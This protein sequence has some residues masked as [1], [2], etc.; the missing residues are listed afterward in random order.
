MT[1]YF[2]DQGVIELSFM[3]GVVWPIPLFT[4]DTESLTQMARASVFGDGIVSIS[5]Q[6]ALSGNFDESLDPIQN[7]W[8]LAL[9]APIFD[10]NPSLTLT[11]GPVVSKF[12][13]TA[14]AS[15]PVTSTGTGATTL[16]LVTTLELPFMHTYG[17]W[18]AIPIIA[19]LVIVIIWL[20]L[21]LRI[22][23]G[24]R[25]RHH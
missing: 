6:S 4:C 20:G 18:L 10:A 21:K 5:S 1:L 15:I 8:M 24:K 25:R 19:A 14:T 7:P 3:G 16:T 9:V 11:Y 13:V 22:K 2:I 12:V 23:T 17:S